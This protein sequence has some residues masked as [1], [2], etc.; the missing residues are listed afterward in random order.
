MLLMAA[1]GSFPVFFAF[2]VLGQV[3]KSPQHPVGASL[4]ADA[5]GRKAT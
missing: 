5:F 4:I 3:S 2:T 1:A